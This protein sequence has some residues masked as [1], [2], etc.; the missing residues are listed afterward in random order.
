MRLHMSWHQSL[1][2]SPL[3]PHELLSRAGYP[4]PSATSSWGS[5]PEVVLVALSQHK[6]SCD[7]LNSALYNDKCHHA[8]CQSNKSQANKLLQVHTEL[9]KLDFNFPTWNS[10]NEFFFPLMICMQVCIW[11]YH[12]MTEVFTWQ[13]S[14]SFFLKSFFFNELQLLN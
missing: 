7:Y 6:S 14:S 5:L 2:G 10:K 9:G 13:I 12:A 3:F 8:L 1:A 11:K 4:L